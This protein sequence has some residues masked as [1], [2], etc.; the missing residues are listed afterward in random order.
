MNKHKTKVTQLWHRAKF[1]LPCVSILL[2]LLKMQNEIINHAFYVQG[3]SN[4]H[5]STPENS[6]LAKR[7]GLNPGT[8]INGSKDVIKED[9]DPISE[10][11][12]E[13][14][15]T[16]AKLARFVTGVTDA[17]FSLATVTSIEGT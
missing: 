9:V 16:C 5:L 10:T 14:L 6:A 1:L 17:G 3:L 4:L 11:K 15:T 8:D 2:Y 13:A 7:R 12:P